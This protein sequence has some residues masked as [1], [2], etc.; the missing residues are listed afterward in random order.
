[1]NI[2]PYIIRNNGQGTASGLSYYRGW[3]SCPK[4]ST[5]DAEN[6]AS[7]NSS[8]KSSATKI[9]FIFHC[10]LELYYGG[11][12]GQHENMVLEFKNI[13]MSIYEV[14]EEAHF[15]A[16]RLFDAYRKKYNPTELGTVLGLEVEYPSPLLGK[17][18]QNVQTNRIAEAVGLVPFSCRLDMVV[19]MSNTSMLWKSRG[20]NIEPGVWL[21]DHK[22]AARRL[23]N[24]GRK[25]AIDLQ[26]TMQCLVWNA[27]NPDKKCNGVLVNEIY[28][29]QKPDFKTFVHIPTEDTIKQLRSFLAGIAIIKQHLPRWANATAC[30]SW[31]RE[32]YWRSIGMCN[33]Y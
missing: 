25:W 17:A 1:M 27:C 24:M 28:K 29:L 33:G 10:Y 6:R 12:I 23:Q 13:D 5:L 3:A 19:E 21:V 22:T 31:G 11:A 2:I 32:C 9:G 16:K 4:K 20:I 30:F 8:T 7:G 14:D 18:E 26:M 15:E